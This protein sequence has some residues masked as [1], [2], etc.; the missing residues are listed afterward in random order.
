MELPIIR[1]LEKLPE[2]ERKFYLLMNAYNLSLNGFYECS[3]DIKQEGFALISKFF[4]T[5]INDIIEKSSSTRHTRNKKDKDINVSDV[6]KIVESADIEFD[7]KL[8]EW[9]SSFS[10]SDD[11]ESGASSGGSDEL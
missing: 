9:A 11:D 2:K 10:N 3:D 4:E 8:G 6:M 1:F 5:E 7:K